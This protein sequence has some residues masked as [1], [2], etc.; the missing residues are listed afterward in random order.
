M[1]ISLVIETGAAVMPRK[2]ARATILTAD[3]LSLCGGPKSRVNPE[4]LQMHDFRSQRKEY[5]K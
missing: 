5:R 4:S 1:M 3:S 2:C